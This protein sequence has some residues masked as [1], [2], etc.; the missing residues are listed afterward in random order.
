LGYER[1]FQAEIMRIDNSLKKMK[2]N[3]AQLNEIGA[4]ALKYAESLLG[5][6]QEAR[7]NG[8]KYWDEDKQP[9]LSGNA[10]IGYT[11]YIST[12]AIENE[13]EAI[14]QISHEVIH[15][16]SPT[17]FDNVSV[18]EEGLATFFSL[19]YLKHLGLKETANSYLKHLSSESKYLKYYDAYKRIE[20]IDNLFGEI[21]A[22]REANKEIKFSDITGDNLISSDQNEKILPLL[23]KFNCGQ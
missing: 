7:F 15:L 4:E 3:E 2:I 1:N 9:E 16:L 21:K 20:I 23:R 13:T 14:F 18:L 10:E 17:T 8:F 11:I 5:V 6:R 19:F 22:L 12:S